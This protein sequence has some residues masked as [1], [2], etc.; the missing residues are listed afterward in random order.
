MDSAHPDEK[1]IVFF[2]INP[3]RVL[4]TDQSDSTFATTHW[5]PLY[6]LVHWITKDTLFIQ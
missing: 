2:N 3:S 6:K 4:C 5:F 1:L